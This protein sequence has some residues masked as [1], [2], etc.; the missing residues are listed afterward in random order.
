MVFHFALPKLSLFL[1]IFCVY[2]KYLDFFWFSNAHTQIFRGYILL[3]RFDES[4]L[5][6][7][8]VNITRD[9]QAI[10]SNYSDRA[11][12]I[13]VME[14]LETSALLGEKDLLYDAQ[15]KRVLG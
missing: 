8:N 9:V 7:D 5:R 12:L 4:Q 11:S 3:V 13:L 2:L 6:L 10:G 1:S 14:D 15:R